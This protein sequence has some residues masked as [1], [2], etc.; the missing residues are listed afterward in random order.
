M[1]F[2]PS[3]GMLDTNKHVR[4][5]G[6]EPVHPQRFPRQTSI[7]CDGA[8]YQDGSRSE[9]RALRASRHSAAVR[10]NRS[11]IDFDF[12]SHW[13]LP[14]ERIRGGI[15]LTQFQISR[16]NFVSECGAAELH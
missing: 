6:F 16:T 8:A 12:S 4:D 2:Q 3:I 7:T 11:N 14:E 10:D 1:A 5:S 9:L 15:R 13:A